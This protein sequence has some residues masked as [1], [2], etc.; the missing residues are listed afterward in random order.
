MDNDDLFNNFTPW[1]KVENMDARLYLMEQNIS[2]LMQAI[3]I[4]AEHLTELNKSVIQ[5]Q[6]LY[7]EISHNG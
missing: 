7:R 4:H 6:K 3:N 2:A 5:L 1:D